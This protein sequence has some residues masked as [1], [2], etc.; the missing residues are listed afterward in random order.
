MVSGYPEDLRPAQSTVAP[1]S[2]NAM[3]SQVES[4]EP[5]LWGRC[6]HGAPVAVGKNL[7]AQAAAEENSMDVV[8]ESGQHGNVEYNRQR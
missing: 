1:K 4:V 6:S 8:G 2:S 5:S 7:G 3:G